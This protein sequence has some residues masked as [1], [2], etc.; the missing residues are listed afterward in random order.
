M[1]AP[2]KGVCVCGGGGGVRVTIWADTSCITLLSSLV[3][4]SKPWSLQSTCWVSTCFC[5]RLK[6]PVDHI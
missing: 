2:E 1:L 5:Q 3:R 6:S 4:L